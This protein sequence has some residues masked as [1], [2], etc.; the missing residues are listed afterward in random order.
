MSPPANLEHQD[1]P[2]LLT[3]ALRSKAIPAGFRVYQDA[4]VR[5]ASGRVA[6][7]D[8]VLIDPTDRQASMM[9]VRLVR[10]VVE[11]V[12]PGNGWSTG[13]RR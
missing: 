11:I 1:I 6:I 9:D 8:G 5:L 4:G 12:S 7:P 10:L 13:S 3:Q 2:F